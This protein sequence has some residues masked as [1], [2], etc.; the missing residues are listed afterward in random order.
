LAASGGDYVKLDSDLRGLAKAQAAGLELPAEQLRRVAAFLK[1]HDAA[2]EAK[3]LARRIR[4][5]TQAA[6]AEAR[7][8]ITQAGGRAD[9]VRITS[10]GTLFLD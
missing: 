3:G 6:L 8:A 4:P 10:A 1:Q 5:D 2:A 9:A 7:A